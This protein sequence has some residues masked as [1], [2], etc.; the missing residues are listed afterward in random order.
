MARRHTLILCG[1]AV[2]VTGCTV[3]PDYKR[4]DVAVPATYRSADAGLATG[5]GGPTFSGLEWTSVFPDPDLQALIRTALAQN[6]DV[7]VAAARILQAQSLATI[8]G[9]QC[10]T[11]YPAALPSPP[12]GPS[13]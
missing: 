10:R 6:Y 12:P 5:T 8:A 11:P 7:R 3:G 9:S 4:P 1:L 13:P 2:A